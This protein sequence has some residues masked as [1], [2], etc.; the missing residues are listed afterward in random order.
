MFKHQ[1]IALIVFNSFQIEGTRFFTSDE[2]SLQLAYMHHP[3][4]KVFSP[5]LHNEVKREITV[6]QEVFIIQKGKVKVNFYNDAKHFLDREI[7][8]K[9]DVL[10][11][12]S[13]GHSFEVLE[14]LEMFEIKQGPYVGIADKTYF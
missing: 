8:S 1:K 4:G 2:S 10:L 11:Q 9:G 7:L 6:T 12:I 3:E 5:H 14:D 13:G